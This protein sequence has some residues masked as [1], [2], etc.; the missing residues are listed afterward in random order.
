MEQVEEIREELWG[1]AQKLSLGFN[2]ERRSYL[3]L[4]ITQEAA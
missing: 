4:L 3:E 1:L 2:S